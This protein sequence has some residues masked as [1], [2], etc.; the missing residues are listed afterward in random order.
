MAASIMKIAVIGV[1]MVGGPLSEMWARGGHQVF[2]SSRHPE[3]LIAPKDGFKGSVLEAVQFADVILL[4]IPFGATRKL[5]DEVK[6]HMKGKIVIDANNAWE[7]RDGP[8][9]IEAKSTGAGTGL[10]T[11]S[12]LPATR[13]VKAFNTWPFF[14]LRI[15]PGEP[16]QPAVPI[17]ADD[18]EAG[19]IVM[20]L[21]NDAGLE[22]ILLPGGLAAAAKFDT[23]TDIGPNSEL[24]KYEIL[25][26]LG[27]T[28]NSAL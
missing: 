6:A 27:L 11:A 21:V 28:E 10:W 17:A 7:R 20:Q 5:D 3:E 14:R 26:R 18:E 4:A 23:G 15:K 24:T 13:V 16:N 12:I 19:R 1:G 2:V 9:A 22:G 8:D 25:Q